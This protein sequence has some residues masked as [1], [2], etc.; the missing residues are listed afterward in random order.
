MKRRTEG[1]RVIQQL[2]LLQETRK[3][4]P[5]SPVGR[6]ALRFSREADGPPCCTSRSCEGRPPGPGAGLGQAPGQAS[7]TRNHLEMSGLK[8]PD[9][10]NFPT[11]FCIS[12]ARN[13]TKSSLAARIIN[14]HPAGLG[15]QP[16]PGATFL[17]QR[18]SCALSQ[19][20]LCTCFQPPPAPPL[21]MTTL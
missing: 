12:H 20:V 11:E 4:G 16:R 19:P 5:G 8:N 10:L 6:R 7:C 18:A 3:K 13:R 9:P 17:S 2:K 15:R 21:A 1:Q 14:P